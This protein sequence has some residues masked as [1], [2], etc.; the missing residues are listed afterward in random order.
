MFASKLF[1]LNVWRLDLQKTSPISSLA[2]TISSW[3]VWKIWLKMLPTFSQKSLATNVFF[4]NKIS[5]LI[6]RFCIVSLLQ[7][8]IPSKRF[9]RSWFQVLCKRIWTK[10]FLTHNGIFFLT[11]FESSFQSPM[12]LLPSNLCRHSGYFHP[13]IF[14]TDFCPAVPLSVWLSL[15]T[16]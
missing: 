11:V 5:P 1:S 16:L 12:L 13:Q 10:R 9:I 8:F 2:S 15:I 3:L 7:Q 14:M 4:H 6:V